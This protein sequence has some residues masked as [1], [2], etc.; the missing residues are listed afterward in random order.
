MSKRIACVTLDIESDL[1]DKSGRIR[2]FDNTDLMGKYS[3]IVNNNNVKVTGFL[4]TSLI[5]KYSTEIGLLSRTIPIEF[6]VHSHS[7]ERRLEY[8]A[9]EVNSSVTA[10]EDFFGV[11]PIGYRAPNGLI[12][13]ESIFSLI[14]NQFKY[15]A[16]IFP[17]IRLDEYGYSNLHLPNKPFRF[18]HS[19]DEI[20][21]LPAACLDTIRLV[22]SMSYVKF[23][24]LELYKTLMR[25]FP[26][27]DI[28]VIDS[29]PY[30]YYINRIAGNIQGWKRYAHLRNSEE[31]FSV[32]ESVVALLQEKGYEFM[33]M[34]ELYKY[35]ADLPKLPTIPVEKLR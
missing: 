4:V 21:E 29:H 32:F 25:V 16:S 9:N 8:F 3:S 28:V 23:L 13:R 10:Y 1:L 26:L 6:G 18:V 19:N 27:P 5:G 24:G 17:S 31:A 22:F 12:N 15:D 34:S 35:V 20:I 33:F 11:K 30:D 14:E 7:H 2:M